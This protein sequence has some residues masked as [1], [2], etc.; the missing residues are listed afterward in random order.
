MGETSIESKIT[1]TLKIKDDI[2]ATDALRAM[3]AEN[4][5]KY[6]AEA[7]IPKFEDAE[8]KLKFL[9]SNNKIIVFSELDGPRSRHCFQVK[10]CMDHEQI[11]FTVME[12]DRMG[13]D[14]D[15]KQKISKCL[16]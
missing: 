6:E 15:L 14:S 11:D 4:V 13:S 12:L 16:G 10:K 9:I 7:K 2:S 1:G 8:D 3:A 5:A